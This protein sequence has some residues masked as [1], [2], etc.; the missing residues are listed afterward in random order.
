MRSIN[1]I[2]NGSNKDQR[3]I[4]SNKKVKIH[5]KTK[6][7]ATQHRR[8]Q[9][10]DSRTR[11]VFS[12]GVDEEEEEE[13]NVDDELLLFNDMEEIVTKSPEV[14]NPL[15]QKKICIKQ[16]NSVLQPEQSIVSTVRPLLQLFQEDSYPIKK[17]APRSVKTQVA[18]SSSSPHKKQVVYKD[19]YLSSEEDDFRQNKSVLDDSDDVIH[20]GLTQSISMQVSRFFWTPKSTNV[21]LDLWKRNLRDIRGMRKNSHI[22]REMAEEMRE[23]GPSPREIKSKMDNMSR[24]YK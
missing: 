6:L 8:K 16:Y 2:A 7:P 18:V 20:E 23:Y 10:I 5:I 3:E 22:H 9:Q 14:S 1:G 24:K 15:L 17:P 4:N 21:F 19:I 11:E 13:Y 12:P